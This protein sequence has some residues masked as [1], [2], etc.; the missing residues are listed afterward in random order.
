MHST[1]SFADFEGLL[2]DRLRGELPGRMAQGRMASSRSVAWPVP[3]STSRNGAV[4]ILFYPDEQGGINFPVI[5]RPTYDGAHSGQ[6]SFP[7][8]KVD[9]DDRDVIHTALR[10]AWE[11]IRAPWD[12]IRILGQLSEVYVF[13]SDFRVVPVV[14]TLPYKPGF[15][16]DPREVARIHEINLGQISNRQIIEEGKIPIRGGYVTAPFYNYNGLQ[17]WGATAMMISEL[18]AIIEQ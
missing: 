14:G 11:E 15:V 7:G 6:I 10:E 9:P 12:E 18:L 13:V 5:L 1:I 8:G 2:T 17:I 3:R 4:L 16:P